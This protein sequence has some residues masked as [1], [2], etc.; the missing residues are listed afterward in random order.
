MTQAAAK[1]PNM[2]FR[3]LQTGFGP[4]AR[5]ADA[6]ARLTEAERSQLPLW[7]PVALGLGVILW[8]VLPGPAAWATAMLA[9]LALALAG[10]AAGWRSRSGFAVMCAGLAVAAGV[11]L[12]WSRA[13]R[14]AAPVIDRPM[15]TTFAARVT[16]V[17]PIPAR[18][19][20]RLRLAA[21]D[22]PDLPPQ[23]RVNVALDKA[24]AG[25]AEGATIALRARLLPPAPPPLPGG[26]DFARAAWFMQLGATGSAIG[27]VTLLSP[28]KPG[29]LAGSRRQLSAHVQNRLPGSEGAIAAALATGD[30]GAIAET[31]AEA[32]RRSGLAHLLSIS[33][34]HV[35]AMVAGV[36]LVTLRL[37]ALSP[38]LALRW[39][40]VTVAAGAGALAGVGYTLLT[41]AE[42]PTVRSCI[43]ALIVLAGIAM[44]RDAITM[45]LVATGALIVLLLWPESITGPSFQL[46]FAAVMAIVALHEAPAVKALLRRRDEGRIARLGRGVLGLLVTGLAVEAALMPVA[47]AHF[48]K[49]GV[50]GALANMIAIPLTTLVVMPAE[51]LALLLDAVGLGAPAWWVA[52]QALSLLLAIAHL[53]ADAPGSVIALPEAPQWAFGLF[54]A[55]MLWFGLWRSRIRWWGMVPAAA[56]VAAMA[57]ARPPDLLLTGDGRHL[58]VRTDDGGHALLR[59]RA[60]E[61]SRD[62]LAEHAGVDGGLAALDAVPGARC[63][64]DACVVA[65]NRAG[66]RW[67]LLATRSGQPIDRAAMEP[68]CAAADIVVSDRSL[69]GWCRPS[70]I[71]A[72]RAMLQRTGG[73]AIDLKRGRI[74][75]VSA[76]QGRHPWIEP[77]AP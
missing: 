21:N 48:H 32:M 69:P 73:L 42:V 6:L 74:D 59:P 3:P 66:R 75:S 68:A 54:V 38:W 40:L 37:L 16:G 52:G 41:G 39:P 56:A 55:G 47:L 35:T 76:R 63:G 44:G 13:E 8:F 15:V 31:D 24:P 50:F 58:A 29:L 43:A 33:G 5:A 9:A 57:L 70:W 12:I 67:V 2:T 7:L 62:M 20:V 10:V 17:E 36:M 11:V 28:G 14:L 45:R 64:R 61:Y 71:R 34:L 19:M 30:E 22:R 65:L 77:P 46:S 72:D 25:L 18:Q 1:A 26:Y 49:A 53:A 4:L 51:A 27:P 23:I 60:G